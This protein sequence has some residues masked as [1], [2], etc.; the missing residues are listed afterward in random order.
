MKFIYQLRFLMLAESLPVHQE[1]RDGAF[2]L[3][4]GRLETFACSLIYSLRH[5][6]MIST[7]KRKLRCEVIFLQSAE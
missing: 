3:V 2:I 4:W 7:K 1:S 5:S 6:F